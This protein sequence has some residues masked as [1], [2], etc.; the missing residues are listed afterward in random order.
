ML[1]CWCYAL[2]QESL[3]LLSLYCV[4][5]LQGILCWLSHVQCVAV[6]IRSMSHWMLYFISKIQSHSRLLFIL[7]LSVG[8]SMQ[9][10]SVITSNVL[11]WCNDVWTSLL[12]PWI[13]LI[14]TKH[15]QINWKR[16]QNI[17]LHLGKMTEMLVLFVS[18]V[19]KSCMDIHPICY[20]LFPINQHHSFLMPVPSHTMPYSHPSVTWWTP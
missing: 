11:L 9:H 16:S 10:F 8:D 6:R 5:V 2:Y 7:S 13:N 18:D 17:S 14:L 3:L 20:C 15:S 4:H 12:R 1:V 19:L